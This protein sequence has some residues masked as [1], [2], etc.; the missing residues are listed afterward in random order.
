MQ[1][2]LETQKKISDLMK[3]QRRQHTEI[4]EVEDVI[5]AQRDQIIKGIEVR[6]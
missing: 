2:L 5:E 3:K 1:A 4:F 6:M